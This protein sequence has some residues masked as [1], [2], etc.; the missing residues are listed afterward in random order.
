LT[1]FEPNKA[2]PADARERRSQADVQW[3]INRRRPVIGVVFCD[4]TKR[5]AFQ[6]FDEESFDDMTPRA[7]GT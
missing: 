4:K 3:T 2:E 5:M 7:D 6:E 1:C